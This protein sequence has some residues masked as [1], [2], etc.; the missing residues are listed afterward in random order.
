MEK[1]MFNISLPNI[2]KNINSTFITC[3]VE[4]SL[5]IAGLISM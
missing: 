2:L 4:P 5:D 1:L 3:Q